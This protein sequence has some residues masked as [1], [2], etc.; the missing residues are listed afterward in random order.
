MFYLNTRTERKIKTLASQIF[1]VNDS[2]MDKRYMIV[3]YVC[4]VYRT[5]EMNKPQKVYDIFFL[6]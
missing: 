4:I 2:S 3:K 1:N 5:K 6:F